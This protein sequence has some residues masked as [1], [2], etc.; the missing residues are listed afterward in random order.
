MQRSSRSADFLVVIR[1]KPVL[2]QSLQGFFERYGLIVM[3]F[4]YTGKIFEILPELLDFANRKNHG[5]S[6]A[7]IIRNIMYGLGHNRNLAEIG[8]IVESFIHRC[9]FR[10]SLFNRRI[11]E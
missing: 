11:D 6:L 7:L 8:G 3:T 10:E 4:S 1:Y 9:T 5:R 2:L